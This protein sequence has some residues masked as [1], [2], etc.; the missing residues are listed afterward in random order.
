MCHCVEGKLWAVVVMRIVAS[1]IVVSFVI[2]RR[3]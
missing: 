2:E 1:V 3:P